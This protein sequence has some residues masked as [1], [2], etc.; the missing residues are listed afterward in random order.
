MSE[1]RL[2]ILPRFCCSVKGAMAY[3]QTRRDADASPP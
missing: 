1:M 3:L 2:M